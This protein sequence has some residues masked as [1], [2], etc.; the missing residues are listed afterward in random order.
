[1]LLAENEWNNSKHLSEVVLDYFSVNQI[2]I[3]SLKHTHCSAL[4]FHLDTKDE[5]KKSTPVDIILIE[6]KNIWMETE[7]HFV[8]AN[9]WKGA[10]ILTNRSTFKK[11]SLWRIVNRLGDDDVSVAARHEHRNGTKV[12]KD[13][14]QHGEESWKGLWRLHSRWRRP[15]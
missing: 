12:P 14:F 13:S 5:F 4:L 11:A 2:I 15:T 10:D 1:M 8:S 9:T 7:L 3:S 6:R